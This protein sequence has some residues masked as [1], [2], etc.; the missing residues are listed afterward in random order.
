MYQGREER[1]A[2]LFAFLGYTIFGFSFLFSKQALTVAAPFV[3][4]AVRFSVAFLILHC[5]L[6]TGKRKVRLKGKNIKMLLCLGLFQPIVY[7]ICVWGYR[8]CGSAGGGL[9]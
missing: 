9:L 2:L 7:F 3:L 1:F 4:L 5:F 6:L 8:T